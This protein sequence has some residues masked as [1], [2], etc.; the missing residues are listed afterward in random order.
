LLELLSAETMAHLKSLSQKKKL[1]FLVLLYE[2][3]IPEL[4]S[5]LVAEGLDFS[6]FGRAREEFWRSLMSADSSVSRVQLR[7][8]ILNATPDTANFG[9]FAASFALNAALVAAAL[10]EFLADGEDS[11]IIEAV[12]YARDSLHA[13]AWKETGKLVYDQTVRD[14]VEAHPLVHRERRREEDD[15]AFLNGIQDAPWPAHVFH[16][17]QHRAETQRS[18]LD[19]FQ[20]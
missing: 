1:A 3:M 13:H 18:L 4:C 7:E 11:H 8:E 9:T 14:Y 2:R 6:P 15:A 17:I 5:F 19:S 20:S 10:A 12:G 16:M